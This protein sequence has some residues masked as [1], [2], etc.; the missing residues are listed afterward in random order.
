MDRTGEGGTRN[1]AGDGADV[2]GGRGDSGPPP[3]GAAMRSRRLAAGVSLRRLAG[4]VHYDKGY[5][6]RVENGLRE[7]HVDLARLVDAALDADGALITIVEGHRRRAAHPAEQDPDED[8]PE[9]AVPPGYAGP[10]IT[11][12]IVGS[13]P[14]DPV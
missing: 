9:L 6:S 7:A 8:W 12:R 3:F 4:L 2:A 5:L 1:R 14:S 10:A 11:R 13:L